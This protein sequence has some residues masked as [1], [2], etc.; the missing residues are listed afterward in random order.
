MYLFVHGSILTESRSIKSMPKK[1]ELNIALSWLNKLVNKWLIIY[2]KRALF[3]WTQL[4]IPGGGDLTKFNMG[5][6]RGPTPYPFIYHFGR[7][8]SPFI[9]LLLKKRT[10]FT[11]LLRVRQIFFTKL[12]PWQVAC[13]SHLP[14]R[15]KWLS[16]VTDGKSL[17]ETILH[18]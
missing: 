5:R 17:A 12:V 8:G 11:Y 9:N 7:K 4:V 2:R 10:P 16:H 14:G 3:C 6:L 18:N 1:K 13:K 15:L